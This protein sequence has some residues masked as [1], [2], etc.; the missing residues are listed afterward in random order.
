M[1]CKF[2]GDNGTA[3]SSFFVVQLCEWMGF[4]LETTNGLEYSIKNSIIDYFDK[5]RRVS[6]MSLYKNS[7]QTF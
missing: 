7:L 5:K 1:Y 6:F 2:E 3:L 4:S